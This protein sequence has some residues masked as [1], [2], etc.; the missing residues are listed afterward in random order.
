VAHALRFEGSFTP[1]LEVLILKSLPW[2]IG[3]KMACFLVCGLYQGV[4]RYIT[5]SDLFTIFK[6]VVL[7]SILAALAVLYLWRFEGYSRAV[8]LIDGMLLFIAISG[9][10]LIEPLL[11]EWLNHL[12]DKAQRVLIIGAGDTGELILRQLKM[13]KAGDRRAAAFLDDDPTLQGNRIHGVPIL[14]SRRDLGRVVQEMGI[15]EIFIAIEHPPKDLVDQIK[16]YCEE[17]GLRWK[18]AIAPASNEPSQQ[19]NE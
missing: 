19:F 18:L 1:D 4:W 12:E 9:S 5:H 17:N 7:G 3:A 2:V 13:N 11:N 6:A 10:R 16:S 8:F 15:S 14:G